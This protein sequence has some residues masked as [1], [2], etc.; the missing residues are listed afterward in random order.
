MKNKTS[1]THSLLWIFICLLSFGVTSCRTSK[2]KTNT[3]YVHL[4]D[5]VVKIDTVLQKVVVTKA[6]SA[7]A[8]KDAFR[9]KRL[10]DSI[11]EF[12]LQEA[13]RQERIRQLVWQI[14]NQKYNSDTV[15]AQTDLAEA[16][17]AVVNNELMIWMYQYPFDT[18]LVSTNTSTT[19]TDKEYHSNDKLTVKSTPWYKDQW[20]WSSVAMFVITVGVVIVSIKRK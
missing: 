16:W 8:A 11:D 5:S 12:K 3:V 19:V 20:F 4:R 13:M 2:Q 17:A 18:T 15:H 14:Y 9:I 1:L 6:D 10:Q 7:K